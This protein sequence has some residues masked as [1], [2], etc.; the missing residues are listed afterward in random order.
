[1]NIIAT[2]SQFIIIIAIGI[3]VIVIRLN[4]NDWNYGYWQG[5]GDSPRPTP[6]S[7]SGIASEIVHKKFDDVRWSRLIENFE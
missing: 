7:W 3:I 1:M 4:K 6:R 2:S 5:K